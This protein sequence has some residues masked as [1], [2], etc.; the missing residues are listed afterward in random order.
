[1]KISDRET[2]RKKSA[3]IFWEIYNRVKSLENI[4][5][6]SFDTDKTVLVIVDVINGFIREGA[7]ADPR[8]E[9]VSY[10]HLTLPTIHPSC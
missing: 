7:M 3:D 4:P 5:L 6:S 9:S 1:M 10:T 2:I 8:I